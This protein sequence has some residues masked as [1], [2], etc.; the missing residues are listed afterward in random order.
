MRGGDV[1]S[2][3]RSPTLGA[4]LADAMTSDHLLHLTAASLGIRT[5]PPAHSRGQ[6][7]LIGYC[8]EGASNRR[9]HTPGN[10]LRLTL[11]PAVRML[12]QCK[13]EQ[14]VGR[15]QDDLGGASYL[16]ERDITQECIQYAW[17]E[18]F[19]ADLRPER[20]R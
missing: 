20:R 8:V 12:A 15:R 13:I 10:I 14:D 6:H 16:I 9:H 4:W 5:S 3:R 18:C 19:P 17:R 2:P 1:T 11:L 7:A